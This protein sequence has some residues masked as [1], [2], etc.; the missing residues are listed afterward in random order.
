MRGWRRALFLTFLFMLACLLSPALANFLAHNISAPALRLLA[1]FAGKVA[2][3]VLGLFAGLVVALACLMR[4]RVLSAALAL[5]I[6]FNVLWYPLCLTGPEK[7]ETADADAIFALCA[8]LV[9]E[10]NETGRQTISA[11][12]ALALSG[13]VM[14]APASAKAARY[15]EWMRA[16]Q[17]AGMFVPF[18]GEALVDATRSPVAV[19]FTAAHELAHM[20]GI[21]DE[22]EANLVAY[23]NCVSYGGA[24]AY[25]ARLW[26]L[27]YALSRVENPGEVVR[28][29]DA[30]IRSDLSA[31]PSVTG[32]DGD[33]GDVVDMLAANFS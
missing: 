19:P 28:A 17:V 4:P 25:S 2:Y 10:L 27:R 24:F 18:T 31:I 26:A 8:Q 13:D 21:A 7:P 23:E 3:P 16:L 33:Y 5:L 20:M 14:G 12:E 32:V 30:A 6:L 22:G 11:D 1:G 9:S 29:L 15:P